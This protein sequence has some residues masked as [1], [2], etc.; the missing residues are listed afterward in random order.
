MI[1]RC[2][3]EAEFSTSQLAGSE[4][5]ESNAQELKESLNQATY[6]NIMAKGQLNIAIEIETVA[7]VKKIKEFI[8]NNEQSKEEENDGTFQE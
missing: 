8:E 3:Q 4:T 5:D 7:E 2:F 6:K 1:Q